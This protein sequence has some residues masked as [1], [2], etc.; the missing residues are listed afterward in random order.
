VYC[1]LE[2]TR[3]RSIRFLLFENKR[4]FVYNSTVL[5][6]TDLFI[7]YFFILNVYADKKVFKIKG[8]KIIKK[9]S[10]CDRKSKFS[11]ILT[12]PLNLRAA[13]ICCFVTKETVKFSVECHD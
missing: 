2:L 13:V 7:L 9:E 3:E 4:V 11:E 5:R 8:Y 6:L 1:H 10:Y 12:E